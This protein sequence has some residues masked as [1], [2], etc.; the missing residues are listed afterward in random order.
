[1]SISIVIDGLILDFAHNRSR[2]G[3]PSG[4]L[5]NSVQIG[6]VLNHSVHSDDTLFGGDLDVVTL[7]MAVP[8]V[9]AEDSR[10]VMT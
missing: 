7:T 4:A 6:Q 10:L 9:S 1:M 5:E 3:D 2:P 8:S